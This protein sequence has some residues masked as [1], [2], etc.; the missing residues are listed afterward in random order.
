MPEGPA[1]RKG[2]STGVKAAGLNKTYPPING[3]ILTVIAT[4]LNKNLAEKL[5]SEFF[6]LIGEDT[7]SVWIIDASSGHDLKA[8]AY[9]TMGR[10]IARVRERDCHQLLLATQNGLLRM[11]IQSVAMAAGMPFTAFNTREEAE[12]HHQ[13]LRTNIRAAR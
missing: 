7:V 13:Q 5:E 4:E 11:S 1:T 12:M 2:S 3:C 10:F 8:E 9:P 6:E